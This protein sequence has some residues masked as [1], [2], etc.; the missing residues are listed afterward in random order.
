MG[1]LAHNKTLSPRTLQKAYAYG[2]TVPGGGR[3][4]MSEVP[5]QGAAEAAPYERGTSQH[6]GARH[7]TS[8]H[9]SLLRES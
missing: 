9:D 1:Y 5:L 8:S 2:P 4:L 6:I 7:P 3:F